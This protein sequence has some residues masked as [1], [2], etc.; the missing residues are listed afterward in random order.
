MSAAS[1]RVAVIGG[2]WAGI[3]AAVRAVQSGHEVVLYEMAAELGGRA[4]TVP[5]DDD[6]DLDNGQHILIGAYRETLELMR[7]VGASAEALLLRQPLALIRPDGRGL[8]LPLGRPLPAFARGIWQYRGWNWNERMAVLAT[9]GRWLLNR[10]RCPPSR[11]V[12][13]LVT[14]LPTKV[15]DELI[16]PLCVAALNT[17]ADEASGQVFLRVMRDALFGT[18]GGADLLLPRAPLSALLPRPASGWLR[19]RGAELRCGFRVS[20]LQAQGPGWS[21]D[22]EAFD[23]VVLACSA[24]EAA[25]LSE[26]VSPA[27][28]K[29]A[30]GLEYEPIVTVYLWG[31]GARL[32]HPMLALPSDHQR[33]A[34]F[35][36][37]HGSLRDEPGLLALVASGARRWTAE[38]LDQCGRACLN[39]LRETFQGRGWAAQTRIV[40]TLADKR[41]TFRCTPDL[42]RPPQQIAARLYAAGDFVDGPY[43][44]TLEGAVRSGR[45]AAACLMVRHDA[46]VTGSQRKALRA[47]LR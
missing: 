18:P 43:P 45:A 20:A 13:E 17:S 31:E 42:R 1:R 8:R 14:A 16:E 24:T 26:E 32:E 38:G 6:L 5:H 10:F 2:G 12:A 22:G 41:A 29:L 27:W 3:S 34:Q 15:R 37:D 21:V 9:A 35:A 30:A 44:A 25:R 4:R 46:P 23:A 11:T 7:T 28:S 47:A 36:F 33:P 19:S 40:R 39:Q